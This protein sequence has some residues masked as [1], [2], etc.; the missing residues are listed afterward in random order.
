MTLAEAKL[1]GITKAIESGKTVY[2]S[3]CTKV[4]K[5]TPKAWK[6]W[7]DKGL[8]MIKVS[9]KSLYIAAGNRFDCIDY[10]RISVGE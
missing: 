3:T 9:G 10:S 7:A 2:L 5:I 1:D 6:S 8:T 4:T